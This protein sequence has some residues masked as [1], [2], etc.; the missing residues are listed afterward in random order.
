MPVTGPFLGPA[1]LERRYPARRRFRCRLA[2]AVGAD[3]PQ[4]GGSPT[5]RPGRPGGANASAY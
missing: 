4:G 3:R 1:G 2:R 5:R